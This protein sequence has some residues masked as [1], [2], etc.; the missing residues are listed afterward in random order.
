MANVY[1]VK[2]SSGQ[3]FTV[4][5]EEHHDRHGIERFKS[6]LGDILKNSTSSAIGGTISGTVVYFVLKGRK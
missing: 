4:T 3:T 6:I 1:E 5:T 2:T